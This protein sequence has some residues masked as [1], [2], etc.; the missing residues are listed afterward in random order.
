[1][2]QKADVTFDTCHLTPSEVAVMI[3]DL[4]F[5]AEVLLESTKAA[6]DGIIDLHVSLYCGWG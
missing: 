1:M 2:A 3:K 4:G 6:R 5:E